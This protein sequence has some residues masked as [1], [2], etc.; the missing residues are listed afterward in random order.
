M[1]LTYNIILSRIHFFTLLIRVN[2]TFAPMH[3][4][5]IAGMPQRIPDYPT[6]Y[7]TINNLTTLSHIISLF[8]LG[9]FILILCTLKPRKNLK[10]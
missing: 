10:N 7:T 3:F 5:R 2:L 8:S 4:L 1:G 6:I 9:T